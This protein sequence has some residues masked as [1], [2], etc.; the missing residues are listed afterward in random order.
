MN[1]GVRRITFTGLMIALSAIFANI[2][3]PGFPTLAFDAIP[4]YLVAI[5]INPVSGGIIALFGH[6]VTALIHGAPLGIPSHIIIALSMFISAYA[7]GLIF[8]KDKIYRIVIAVIIATLLNTYLSFPFLIFLLRV[9]AAYILPLQIP[10]I[11]A[12]LVNICVAIFIYFP[13]HSI[14]IDL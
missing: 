7:L 2:P 12:S 1:K 6:L 10:L 11:I 8:K 13:L 14:R 5:L 3:I 9:P 4:G